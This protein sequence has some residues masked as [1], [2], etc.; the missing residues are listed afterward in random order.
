MPVAIS[1]W[2][3]ASRRKLPAASLGR[4][5]SFLPDEDPLEECIRND[6]QALDGLAEI[7]FVSPFGLPAQHLL[8]RL[9]Q[10]PRPCF[11]SAIV[12]EAEQMRAAMRWR[13]AL[14]LLYGP[15]GLR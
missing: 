14:P 11:R 8:N 5:K 10:L 9:R 6:E 12:K 2:T 3:M 1:G 4:E 13:H 15:G 7:L